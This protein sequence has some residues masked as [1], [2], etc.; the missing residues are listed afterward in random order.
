MSLETTVQFIQKVNAVLGIVFPGIFAIQNNGDNAGRL[1]ACALGDI[2][3]V[4][5]QV[6]YRI[7]CVPVGVIKTNQV[8]QAVISKKYRSGV[9]TETNRRVGPRV[10]ILGRLLTA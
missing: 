7:L 6:A 10:M 4:M 8:R 1:C 9:V 3:Q 2:F 5:Y